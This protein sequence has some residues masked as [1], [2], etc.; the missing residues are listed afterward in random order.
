MRIGIVGAG[1]IG[2]TFAAALSRAHDVVLLA[3]R[4]AVVDAILRD[5]VAIETS[6]GTSHA[7]VRATTDPCAFGDRDAVVVAVKASA[8]SEALAPLHGKLPAHALV[9]SVQNGIDNAETARAVLPGARVVAG[10]TYQGVIRLDDTRVRVVNRGSTIFARDDSMTPTSGDLAA[11]FFEAGL[12][13]GVVDDDFRATLWGKLMVVATINP[14][15]ALTGRTNGEIVSDPDLI[16]LARA[17]CAE[18]GAVAEAEGFH[19]AGLWS[20][21]EAAAR[22]TAANRSSMLQDLDAG[23]PTEIDAISGAILRHGRAH[24]IAVLLTETVWRLV[25]ARERSSDAG[26]RGVA[27]A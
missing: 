1:A 19:F 26:A 9:A 3:R 4:A 14:L 22:S 6:D 10:T 21:V 7:A 5:G 13:A 18:A 8:T 11:A 17:L 25:R 20:R 24:G 23:R 27:R 16:P 15:G 2:L 12:Q